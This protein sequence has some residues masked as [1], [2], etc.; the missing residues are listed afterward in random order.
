MDI[1]ERAVV[2]ITEGGNYRSAS[3]HGAHCSLRVTGLVFWKIQMAMGGLTKR[4][5]LSGPKH[6]RGARI[7]VLENKVIVSDSPNVFR[8]DDLDGDGKKR[9]KRELL[10]TGLADSITIM[11]FTP[12]RSALTKVILT[13]AMKRNNW[14]A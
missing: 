8:V 6:Q 2:W 9:T 4:R 10:F 3:S 12:L 11:E 7:C 5:F 1:D 13:W 14:P